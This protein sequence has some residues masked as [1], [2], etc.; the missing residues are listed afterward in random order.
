MIIRQ[1][2]KGWVKEWVEG[3]ARD[4]FINIMR[5]DVK[6]CTITMSV[7]GEYG[8]MKLMKWFS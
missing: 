1:L 2:H 6:I 5:R 4:G 7:R 8:F 3:W